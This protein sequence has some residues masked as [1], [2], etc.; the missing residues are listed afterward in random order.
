M[1]GGA[2]EGAP[3]LD[4]SPTKETDMATTFC[5]ALGTPVAVRSAGTL[6]E[7]VRVTLLPGAADLLFV[8]EWLHGDNGEELTLL[9][10]ARQAGKGG[11]LDRLRREVA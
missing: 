1:H 2:L 6:D 4:R 3:L 11:L 10:L 7:G 9:A 5:D 8:D